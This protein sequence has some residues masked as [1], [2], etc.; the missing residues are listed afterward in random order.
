MLHGTWRQ[1]QENSSKFWDRYRL[2]LL[3]EKHWNGDTINE[4]DKTTD[5]IM[6]LL[7]NP[8][9]TDGFM[10]RGLCIGDVQSGKTST[11]IGLVNKAADAHY[12]VIILL[13]G[14]IEKIAP[15]RPNNV[16]TKDLLGWT[17]MHL[18]LRRGV[19]RLVWVPLIQ[20]PAVGRLRPPQVTSM[21][22]LPKR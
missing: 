16:L 21:Q 10:R 4:L 11:Y 17:A 12:R 1:R 18:L 7:G 15:A 5:E 3:R 6:D 22:P 8:N 9:Q 14:T 2:Y 19:F 20:L 13:T